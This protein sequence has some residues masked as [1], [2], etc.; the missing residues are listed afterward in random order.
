MG[1]DVFIPLAEA[2]GQILALGR[3]ILRT[4]TAQAAAWNR[5]GGRRGSRR[6]G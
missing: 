1:P 3:W 4:A 2:T 6:C 5:A